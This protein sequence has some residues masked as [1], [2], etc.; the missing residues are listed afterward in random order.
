M[1]LPYMFALFQA[2]SALLEEGSTNDFLRRERYKYS[3][4]TALAG[5]IVQSSRGDTATVQRPLSARGGYR[6]AARAARTGWN[7][8]VKLRGETADLVVKVT[9]EDDLR[10]HRFR[11]LDVE[12]A[13]G[14]TDFALLQKTR[15]SA[16][17][18]KRI[19]WLS[20]DVSQLM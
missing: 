5:P 12:G 11:S 2:T 19:L 13:A 16:T 6:Y 17:T 8:R 9:V 18:P 15:P 4:S 10:V 20:H 3:C 14:E 7:Y 1:Q